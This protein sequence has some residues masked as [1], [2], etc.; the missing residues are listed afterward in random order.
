[1]CRG[2]GGGGGCKYV[3]VI[4][5]SLYNVPIDLDLNFSFGVLNL[6]K[7]YGPDS[8]FNHV[9]LTCF[10]YETSEYEYHSVP[11]NLSCI[12]FPSAA[13]YKSNKT[14]VTDYT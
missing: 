1:M 7:H 3:Q 12:S 10:D 5:I 13:V 14:S 4:V 11:L 6:F 9:S 2:G 8:V